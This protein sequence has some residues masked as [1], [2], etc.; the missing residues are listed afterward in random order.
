METDQIH[1]IIS[2]NFYTDIKEKYKEGIVECKEADIGMNLIIKTDYFKQIVGYYMDCNVFNTGILSQLLELNQLD[3]AEWYMNKYD[4]D[5]FQSYM[6]NFI[7]NENFRNIAVK[8][9][10]KFDCYYMIQDLV[11]YSSNDELL[12]FYLSIEKHILE[13]KKGEFKVS[14]DTSISSMWLF[15]ISNCIQNNHYKILSRYLELN[16]T[17]LI[18]NNNKYKNR[19]VIAFYE[20]I[21]INKLEY[22]D[23]LFKHIDLKFLQNPTEKLADFDSKLH[24]DA[25]QYFCDL[26][27]KKGIGVSALFI[28]SIIYQSIHEDKYEI[29][30][31]LIKLFPNEALKVGCKQYFDL[32]NFRYLLLLHQLEQEKKLTG[33]S[34]N[35]IC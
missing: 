8:M 14:P 15:T 12:E 28:E 30:C 11:S 18:T 9:L 19:I 33:K 29:F 34:I 17:L 6:K 20:V 1:F 25:V 23:L 16:E 7:E 10:G 13:E 21:L 24:E 4:D 35:I 31:N 22:A 2:K 27:V 5:C 26:I 32:K 3:L